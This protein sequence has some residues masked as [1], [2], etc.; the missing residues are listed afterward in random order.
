MMKTIKNM[1]IIGGYAVV[2]ITIVVLI[3]KYTLNL[4]SL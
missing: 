3:I 4:W 2:A 1:I